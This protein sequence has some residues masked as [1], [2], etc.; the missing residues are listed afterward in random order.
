MPA[1]STQSSADLRPRV[2]RLAWPVITE[3]FLQTLLGIVDTLL[4]ARLG[5]EALAGVGAAVQIMFFVI[6]ALSATSVGASVLVAQAVGGH[7]FADA[8]RY[9]KQALLWSAILSVPLV[10]VGLLAAE[11]L[12]A[13]FGMEPEVT[14]IGADYLRVTMGTVIVLSLMFLSSGVMRGAGDSRT[15]MLVVAFINVIN[16][17]LT[18]GL[19]FGAFGLPALGAVG[20]AW[21]TFIARAIG[22]VI[23]IIIL[24]RGVN[25][26]SIRG[27]ADWRPQ[28]PTA[29]RILKIGVPAGLEQMIISTGFLAMTIFV[30]RISTL[31]LAAH[32][33]A[34]NAL[35]VSFLPGIGF[36]V[37]ATALVGQAIG[38]QRPD[39]GDAIS[40]IATRWSV[41]WMSALGVVFFFFAEQ[42][43]RF[44][45]DD[46][47]VIELGAAGLRPLALTQ[48]FW[49][50]LFVQSGSLRG[51]G[52]TR[53]P[54]RVNTITIW[55][56]VLTG[57]AL[58]LTVGGGL[59][60]VWSAFLLTAPV[61]ALLL[62]R[63]FQ[64][65]IHEEH[66]DAVY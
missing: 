36:G 51:T 66:I 20:S 35:S 23:L 28:V 25:G 9:A 52:D 53:F 10:I 12:I 40:R 47:V 26:V 62:W 63:R 21:A 43:M 50:V 2:F 27:R 58:A 38:A 64:R 32:R 19:I 34:F 60:T 65:T 16:I 15:P 33:I 5:A 57:G 11:T 6:S 18:Y 48:P 22:F 1:T 45:T 42:I 49:A 3:N 59:A 54:L 14:E 37:A 39:E 13:A 46:P 8:S 4:V 30:A 31:A 61:S 29:R 55:V 17:F 44:F 41:A 56:A 7:A 24:H